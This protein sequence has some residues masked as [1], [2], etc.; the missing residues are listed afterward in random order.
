VSR[1][2]ADALVLCGGA[3]DFARKKVFT[4]LLRMLRHGALGA[5]VLGSHE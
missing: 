4:A 2:P 1:E 3:A 5:A